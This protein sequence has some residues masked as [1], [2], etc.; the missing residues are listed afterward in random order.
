[1]RACLRRYSRA[2][3]DP[4]VLANHSDFGVRRSDVDRAGETHQ[5][6]ALASS[7]FFQRSIGFEIPFGKKGR[8]IF[9]PSPPDAYAA[10]S[11]SITTRPVWPSEMG[12]SFPRTQRAK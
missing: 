4:P 8:A 6:G 10:Y 7:G 9:R 2:A 1:M 5:S 11:T 3:K 12:V